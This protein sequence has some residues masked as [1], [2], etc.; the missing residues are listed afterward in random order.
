VTACAQLGREV[1]GRGGDTESAKAETP[2]ADT[3]DLF[4][5]CLLALRV[6]D[7]VDAYTNCSAHCR[8]VSWRLVADHDA[9]A[10]SK[11]VHHTQAQWEAAVEPDGV[12]DTSA[13][14]RYPA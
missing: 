3:T 2:V 10:A 5:A 6:P 7:Q 8:T 1:F 9:R 14:N 13:G 12:T 4:R 11:L